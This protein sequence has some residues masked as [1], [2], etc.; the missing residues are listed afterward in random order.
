M[1]H[2]V[3]LDEAHIIR[4]ISSCYWKSASEIRSLN[5]W[6]LTGTPFVNKPDDIRSLLWFLGV[7]PLCQNSVFQ[8][9]VKEPIKKRKER[10]LLVVRAMMAHISLRRKKVEVENVIQLPPKT[11]EIVKVPFPEGIH[12]SIHDDLYESAR[13]TFIALFRNMGAEIT[14]FNMYFMALVL[15]V[16]QSCC[17]A[18]LIPDEMRERAANFLK[19][20]SKIDM[21]SLSTEEALELLDKLRG[22]FEEEPLQECTVCFNELD[23]D[24]A[25]IL[26]TCQHVFCR[27]CLQKIQ[28]SLCPMCR[29]EYTESDMIEKRLATEVVAKGVKTTPAAS[30]PS[31][32]AVSTPAEDVSP[33]TQAILQA[34]EETE[35]D[36]KVVIF[37]QWTSHLDFIARELR[38][39][40]W[41]FTR[42]DGT[43]DTDKRLAAMEAFDTK[44]CESMLTPKIIL[45]SMHAC[46][47]GINLTRGNV[48]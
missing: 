39:A 28:N 37:S 21:L 15:R 30:A 4:N 33:K 3:V 35:P 23:V 17:H 20:V 29:A 11:V 45:C 9:F 24:S 16:R 46:G 27:P 2:R 40:G 32:P 36:E 18:D 47:T 25:V 8:K 31:P 10:G 5:R 22:T 48:V 12:K 7:Q 19:Q 42:I 43:M 13:Q 6:C 1:L 41:T 44:G 38:K 14:E 34:I 26:K